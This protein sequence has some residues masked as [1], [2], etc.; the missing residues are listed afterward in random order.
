M[1]SGQQENRYGN[2]GNR[3]FPI[4]LQLREALNCPIACPSSYSH[5]LRRT[6]KL[7][8]KKK[9]VKEK[10]SINSIAHASLPCL[11]PHPIKGS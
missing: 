1:K 6:I 2:R 8:N 11:F 7:K 10:K 5:S 4:F 3:S 9:N